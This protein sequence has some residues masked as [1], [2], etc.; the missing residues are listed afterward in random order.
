[1]E[2]KDYYRIIGL[3]RDASQDEIKRAYRKLARKYHPDISKEPDAE[4]RFK[5]LGEAY[6]VL[7]DPEKRAAYDRLGSDWRS[8]QEF[9]PPPG[10][11]AGGF[12]H[13]GFNYGGAREDFGAEDAYA[14]ESGADFGGFSDFFESLFGG[15]DFRRARS[16]A[17]RGSASTAN[18]RAGRAGMDSHARIAISPEDSY[19]GATRAITLQTVEPDPD[20]RLRRKQRTLNVRI[21]R[22]VYQGQ[23]IRL[24]GQG[25][26]GLGRGAAGDLYLEID[27]QPHPIYRVEGRDVFLDLPITPWEAALGATVRA[28]TPE[29]PAIS[30]KI[31][32]GAQAGARLRVKGRGIPATPPGDFYTLLQIV[33]PPAGT[34]PEQEAWREL[35]RKIPFNPRKQLGV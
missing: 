8:G 22:G 6:A 24:A 14:A 21:P 18:T 30:L 32:P 20:G 26:P 4:Q 34:G 17:G 7:G 33:V 3:G 10:W 27:F 1:M 13:G 11:G 2:Y 31:P 19:R 29:G 5:E 12:D 23:H 28:P 9:R 25:N 16:Q 15:A 35:E